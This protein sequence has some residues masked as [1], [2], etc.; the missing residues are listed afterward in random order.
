MTKLEAERRRRGLSQTQLAAKARKLS[1]SDISRM[2]RL[3]QKPYPAQAERIARVLG[4]RP[5]ELTEPAPKSA[6]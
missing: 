5:E 2:E 3:W 1:A 4:L 6:A